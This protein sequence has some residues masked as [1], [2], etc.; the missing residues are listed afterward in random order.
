MSEEK[1]DLTYSDFIHPRYWPTWLGIA[2]LWLIAHTPLAFQR[3]LGILM[4]RA[5]YYLL[6]KRRHIAEVN[7]NLCFPELTSDQRQDLVKSAFDNN[8]IGYFEAASAWFTGKERFRSITKAHG[9][10]NLQAA[11]AKGKGVILLGGHFT[12]LDL[13][14]ALFDIYSSAASMQRDHD[15]PLFNLVMTRARSK[16]CHPVLSKDDLRGLIRLLKNGK[17]IWYATDQDY[18]RRGS[19][20]APFF[21]VPAATITTTSRIAQKTGSLVVPFSHFRNKD[22]GYDIYFEPALS[23]YPTGDDVADAKATNLAIENAIRRYPAQYLWMHRRFKTEPQGKSHR[24]YSG[25]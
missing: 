7:I 2:L 3:G 5:A 13:G 22:G 12:T 1:R 16:F 9:L 24:K 10:E 8:A 11:Q 25:K 6:P 4:G 20:F 23:N 21:K 18:G 17:T 14:G 15:N 19:V